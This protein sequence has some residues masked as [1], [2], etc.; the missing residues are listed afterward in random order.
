MTPYHRVAMARDYGERRGCAELVG[1]LAGFLE[2]EPDGLEVD[3]VGGHGAVI[4]AILRGEVIVPPGEGFYGCVLC[5][6]PQGE[7][8]GS[9]EGDARQPEIEFLPAPVERGEA[10]RGQ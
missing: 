8:C 6:L 2:T 7:R 5:G 1:M 9:C 4:V 3:D 10:D